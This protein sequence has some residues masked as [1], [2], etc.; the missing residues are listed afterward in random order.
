MNDFK[1]LASQIEELQNRAELVEKIEMINKYYSNYISHK[2]VERKL[3]E[4]SG[5]M[6]EFEKFRRRLLQKYTF[7]DDLSRLYGAIGEANAISIMSKS[8]YNIMSVD[9]EFKRKTN[10][11]IKRKYV[12]SII[13]Y[14][15][16]EPDIGHTQLCTKL[17]IKANFLTELMNNLIDSDII[18]KY[19]DGKYSYYELTARMAEYY[20]R[21]IEVDYY[22]YIKN[23]YEWKTDYNVKRLQVIRAKEKREFIQNSNIENKKKNIRRKDYAGIKNNNKGIDKERAELAGRAAY[24]F[25]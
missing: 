21:E 22:R 12:K 10:N 2:L 6:Y 23:S 13:E 15:Y 5:D 16:A 24:R 1:N 19:R 25:A 4:I 14:V 18:V 9:D 11:L 17:N 8:I 7:N 20:R 3:D